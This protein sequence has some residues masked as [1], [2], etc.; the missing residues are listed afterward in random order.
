LL[1]SDRRCPD[2]K[3]GFTLNKFVR[4][5]RA[6]SVGSLLDLELRPIS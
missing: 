2:F 6:A 1:A 3:H 4:D 5:F